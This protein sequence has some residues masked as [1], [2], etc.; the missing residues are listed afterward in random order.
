M[1]RIN[2]FN[3]GINMDTRGDQPNTEAKFEVSKTAKPVTA[4]KYVTSQPTF[5]QKQGCGTRKTPLTKNECSAIFLTPEDIQKA[6]QRSDINQIKTVST[7]ERWLNKVLEKHVKQMNYK[8]VVILGAGFD[9]RAFKKNL[10]NQKDKKNAEIYSQVKYWEIDKKEILDEK[11]QIFKSKGFDKNATYIRADYTKENFIEKLI[12][13]DIKL[14]MPTLIIWEGNLMYL[15]KQQVIEVINNIKASFINFTIA[16]DYLTQSHIDTLD[17]K[18]PLKKMWKTGIDD[19]KQFA[20]QHGLSI[21]SIRNIAALEIE[22]EVDSQP[23][24]RAEQY[25]VCALKR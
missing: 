24:K 9:I 7:R 8:Q 23:S 21:T 11:E 22:Y 19:I 17:S 12:A 3:K 2:Q 5:W 15:E 10:T 14:D 20:G 16:F 13:A 4:V 1:D 6:E 18:S 25:S